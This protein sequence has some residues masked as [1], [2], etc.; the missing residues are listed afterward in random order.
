MGDYK[1]TDILHNI[2]NQTII[3]LEKHWYYI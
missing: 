2:V 3:W 1:L